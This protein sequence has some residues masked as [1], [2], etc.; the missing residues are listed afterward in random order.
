M[1]YEVWSADRGDTRDHTNSD[2]LKEIWDYNKDDCISL[3]RLSDFL[4]EVQLEKGFTY[5]SVSATET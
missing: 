2:L 4:R 1:T 5:S 3:I